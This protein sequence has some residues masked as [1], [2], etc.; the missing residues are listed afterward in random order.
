MLRTVN[1]NTLEQ[2]QDDEQV[3]A[4]RFLYGAVI[5]RAVED[6]LGHSVNCDGAK[7]ISYRQTISN[8]RRMFMADARQYIFK[9]GGLFEQHCEIAGVE[10]PDKIRAEA[11][12]K[13]RGLAA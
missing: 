1:A 4:C 13:C 8:Q 3:L 11:K 5:H 6:A 10:N 9:R 7:R 12:I 2:P